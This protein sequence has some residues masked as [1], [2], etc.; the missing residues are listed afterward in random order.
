[1]N[2]KAGAVFSGLTSIL[3]RMKCPRDLMYLATGFYICIKI[4][5]MLLFVSCLVCDS[6]STTDELKMQDA[7]RCLLF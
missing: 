6:D 3:Y 1:M 2:L 7:G 5:Y 4:A